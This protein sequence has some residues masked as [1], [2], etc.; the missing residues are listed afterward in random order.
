[1]EDCLSDDRKYLGRGAVERPVFAI[2]RAGRL[3][4]GK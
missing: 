1:M 3:F 4:I 2:H